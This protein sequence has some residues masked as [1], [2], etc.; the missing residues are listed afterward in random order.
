MRQR[1]SRVPSNTT[2]LQIHRVFR[3]SAQR[4][5]RVPTPSPL[6]SRGT[7]SVRVFKRNGYAE[8]NRNNNASTEPSHPR[9]TLVSESAPGHADRAPCPA[10]LARRTAARPGSRP[11]H[12]HPRPRPVPS[13][14]A[15][16]LPIV[17]PPHHRHSCGKLSG[18]NTLLLPML[19]VLLVWGPRGE[20]RKSTPSTRGGP[21]CRWWESCRAL[22]LS[23]AT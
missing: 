23:E 22:G 3:A 8:A 11:P 15:S 14:R 21:C 10:R 4:P 12:H 18:E 2:E 6:A 7:V 13:T 16:G 9:R 19:L 1:I 20:A 5:S 17:L